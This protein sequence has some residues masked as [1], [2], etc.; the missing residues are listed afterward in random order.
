MRDEAGADHYRVVRMRDV[1]QLPQ[2]RTLQTANISMGLTDAP[3][4]SWKCM[5]IGQDTDEYIPASRGSTIIFLLHQK[6][7]ISACTL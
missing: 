1:D 4:N 5:D 2:T 3:D 7:F 6:Y